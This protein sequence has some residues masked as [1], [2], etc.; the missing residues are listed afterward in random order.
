MVGAKKKRKVAKKTQKT[1]KSR[2]LKKGGH[3]TR[4]H[5]TGKAPVYIKTGKWA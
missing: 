5:K 3:S 2:S 1:T 4:A